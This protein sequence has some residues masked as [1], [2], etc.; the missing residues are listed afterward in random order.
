MAQTFPTNS[1]IDFAIASANAG[2]AAAIAEITPNSG[3]GVG[4]ASVNGTYGTTTLYIESSADNGVSWNSQA[5]LKLVDN[6]IASMATGLAVTANTS[7]GWLFEVVPG[8]QYRARASAIAS[9]TLNV[10]IRS[11]PISY[12]PLS[13]HS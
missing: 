7:V 5:V 8:C 12:N 2:T 1:V 3:D 6:T 13:G 10:T 4:M 9:G 11:F